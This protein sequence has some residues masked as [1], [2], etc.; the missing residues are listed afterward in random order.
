MHPFPIGA[1]TSFHDL[2]D[3]LHLSVPVEVTPG[4]GD[5]L[6]EDSK[7][8]GADVGSSLEPGCRFDEG[9]ESGLSYLLGLLRIQAGTTGGPK[10][11]TQIGVD[12]SPKRLGISCPDPRREFRL[13]HQHVQA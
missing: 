11:L 1:E 4:L 9:Y 2:L 12:N 13:S 3:V 6:I 5:F 7:Q 8:P 10:D